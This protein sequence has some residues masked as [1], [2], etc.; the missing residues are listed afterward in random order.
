MNYLKAGYFKNDALE[1]GGLEDLNLFYWSDDFWVVLP[2]WSKFFLE[3]GFELGQQSYS[4]ERL[5]V[6]FALPVRSYAS[7]LVAAGI[8]IARTNF[9]GRPLNG[10]LNEHFEKLCRL[11]IGTPLIFREGKRELKGKFDGVAT[12]KKEKRIRVQVTNKAG[13]CLTH[14]LNREMS[15][16]VSISHGKVNLPKKQKGR[17]VVKRKKF[18][19]AMLEG[20]N[21][22]TYDFVYISRLESVIVGPVNIIGR[23]TTETRVAVKKKDYFVEGIFQ[24]VLRIR[25]FLP[26]NRAFRTELLPGSGT[27]NMD[28]EIHPAVTIY[29]GANGY[30]KLRNAWPSFSDVIIL[31]RTE[32][33]FDGAVNILNQ[34]YI[35]KRIESNTLLDSLT[36]PAG[37]EVIAYKE[38][39]CW[40]I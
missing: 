17:V 39:S 34:D 26:D 6:A 4:G 3:F 12:Y 13:G 1:K 29:D 40:N 37:I 22:N 24:D 35:R 27:I 32:S 5:V 19:D 7:S 2:K 9:D 8:V 23:E 14:L 31:D 38:R 36:I 16:S 28:N 20:T 21:I 30:L 15:K 11:R 10:D 33:N 18:L 25:R